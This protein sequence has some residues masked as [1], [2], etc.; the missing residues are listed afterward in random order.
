MSRPRVKSVFAA[1]LVA[2]MFL[3]FAGATVQGVLTAVERR[4]LP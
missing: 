4:R 3:A 1:L 2:G